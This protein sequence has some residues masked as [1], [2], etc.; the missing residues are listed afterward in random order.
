MEYDFSDPNEEVLNTLPLPVM[1]SEKRPLIPWEAAIEKTPENIEETWRRLMIGLLTK[2]SEWS[3]ENEW[4]ILINSTDST[5]VR[6]PRISCIYL[7]A[8]IMEENRNKILDI[9]RMKH[10]PVK[11]MKVDRGEYDLHAVSLK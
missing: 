9:A 8:S 1:Y 4:R 11:Q 5:E 2:D 10:I 3:Y 6:M 7:G